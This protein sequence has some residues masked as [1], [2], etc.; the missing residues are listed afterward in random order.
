MVMRSEVLPPKNTNLSNGLPFYLAPLEV[1]R[2]PNLDVLH[3]VPSTY[4]TKQCTK[5]EGLGVDGTIHL[6]MGG[7]F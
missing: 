4:E 3:G 5:R 1:G 7:I 2:F 6:K